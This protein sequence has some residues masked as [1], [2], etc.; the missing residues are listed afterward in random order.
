MLLILSKRSL[1]HLLL[2]SFLFSTL[3]IAISLLFPVD[4][5]GRIICLLMI[6]FHLLNFKINH[7]IS[8]FIVGI[9][10]I[11]FIVYLSSTILKLL[12][13]TDKT[14]TI[15]YIFLFAIVGIA[16]VLLLLHLSVYPKYH[17]WKYLSK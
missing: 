5:F 7:P 17:K 1:W 3:G 4:S 9:V 16:E 14:I 10:N 15:N 8:S 2:P 13:V 11:F 12:L 6:L